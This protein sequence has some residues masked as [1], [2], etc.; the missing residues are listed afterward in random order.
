[1]PDFNHV[2]VGYV[3][4]RFPRF[5]E[6]FI[7]NEILAL[8][9]LGVTVHVFSL[10]KPGPEP[11]H[12]ALARF[13][14][15]IHYLPGSEMIRHL[16]IGGRNNC[17]ASFSEFSTDAACADDGVWSGKSLSDV[18][19]LQMQAVVLAGLARRLKLTHLHAHFASDPTTVTMLG[20]E[21]ASLPYSFTAH[22]K[23]IFHCYTTQAQDNAARREKISRAKFVTTVTDFNRQH[24]VRIAPESENKIR[25]VYN[26][27]DLSRFAPFCA[28]SRSSASGPP[29]ILGIGRLVEKKGF[30]HLVAA[31][32]EL[33]RRGVAFQCQLIGDG[34]LADAL[35]SLIQRSNV[36]DCVQLLAPQP[37]EEL[38]QTLARAKLSVL[39]CVVTQSGDRDALPTVLLE[40]LAMGVPVVTTTVNG[41]PE[42]TGNGQAG[43]LVRPG[44]STALADAMELLLTNEEMRGRLG[45]QARQRSEAM[46]D[47]RVNVKTLATGF[48]G[49]P[50]STDTGVT[51]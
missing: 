16:K 4:K 12:G 7:L 35:A 38:V 50:T 18:T 36:G 37:Q 28:S 8:Q 10:R 45:R 23:D 48:E 13:R 43:L 51:A 29:L 14:G 25:R 19:T 15:D 41:C 33:K 27:I 46:F 9:E 24:L 30:A 39:P 17:K 47:L 34:P 11:V 5:S 49:L 1:M 21:L 32:Q 26:G 40:S 42:I 44:D 31:C 22:A 20:S 2:R 6:T 3:V